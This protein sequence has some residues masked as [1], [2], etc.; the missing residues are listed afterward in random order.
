MKHLTTIAIILGG[1]AILRITE[2]IAVVDDAATLGP[3]DGM[4][5]AGKDGNLSLR[6]EDGHLAWGEEATSRALSTAFVHVGRALEPLMA[7]DHF[8][9]ARQDLNEELNPIGEELEETMP[10]T[11]LDWTESAIA[12]MK[13]VPFFV[14][15]GVVRGIEQ[16]AKD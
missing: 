9:E 6:N 14:R 11:E 5:L 1:L 15:K 3:V 4:W 12:R 16:F 2:A 7:A 13:N 8:V 10:T